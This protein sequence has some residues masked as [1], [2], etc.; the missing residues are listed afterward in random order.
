METPLPPAV[1]TEVDACDVPAEASTTIVAEVHTE[2][3]SV[4]VNEAAGT[5]ASVHII[6]EVVECVAQVSDSSTAQFELTQSPP[7][8]VQAAQDEATKS[9]EEVQDE[10]TKS[11]EEVQ[12][13]AAKSPEEVSM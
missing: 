8:I 6:S 11:T 12:D 13:E 1:K 5:S 10:A 9:T 2:S 3:V 4:L 7:S